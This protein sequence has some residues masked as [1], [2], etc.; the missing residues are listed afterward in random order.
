MSRHGLEAFDRT[1]QLTHR[2]L[3]D[4]M[5]ELGTDDRQRAWHALSVVLHALRD[6]LPDAEAA[7]LSAQ[8][9]MLVR[10]MFFEGWRPT[11][12][13]VRQARHSFEREIELAFQE[14][15]PDGPDRTTE[16]VLRVLSRHVSAGEVRDLKHVLPREVRDIWESATR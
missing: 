5:G 6:R 2:W 9:P 8:L 4:L 7:H 16:A 3:D 10:G 13:P 12:E 11:P 1:L 14:W 15:W